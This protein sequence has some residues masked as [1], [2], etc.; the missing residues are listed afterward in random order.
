MKFDYKVGIPWFMFHVLYKPKNCIFITKYLVINSREFFNVSAIFSWKSIGY[1]SC[2]DCKD[3]NLVKN[4]LRKSEMSQFG[5]VPFV[6]LLGATWLPLA[7]N[8]NAPF[9]EFDQSEA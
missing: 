6:S 1:F 7:S 4:A 8:E 3:F 2:Y 5:M 9:M